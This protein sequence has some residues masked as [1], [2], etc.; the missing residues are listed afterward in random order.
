MAINLARC[1]IHKVNKTQILS[2]WNSHFSWRR[3]ELRIEYS[4]VGARISS[5]CCG[6]LDQREGMR[7]KE[8]FLQAV[9]LELNVSQGTAGAKARGWGSIGYIVAQV[10][11]SRGEPCLTY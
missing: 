3:Q 2:S 6:S 4:I 5:E 10:G 8:D 1:Y 9:M 11:P 7:I